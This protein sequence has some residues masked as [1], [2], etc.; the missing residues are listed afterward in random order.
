MSLLPLY[1]PE[2]GPRH[3]RPLGEELGLIVRRL[4]CDFDVPYVRPLLERHPP[5]LS[6]SL[7]LEVC[8]QS[9]G[10]TVIDEHK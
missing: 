8:V 5:H 2:E 6:W 7:G 1:C 4:A 10:G 9:I 3:R